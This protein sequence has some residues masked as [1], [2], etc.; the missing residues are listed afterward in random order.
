M[1][2]SRGAGFAIPNICDRGGSQKVKS[3][4]RLKAHRLLLVMDATGIRKA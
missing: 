3:I 2:G 1:F 4:T